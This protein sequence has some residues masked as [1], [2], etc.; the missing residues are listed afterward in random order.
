MPRER[1]RPGVTR[2][3]LAWGARNGLLLTTLVLVPGGLAAAH[4]G[5]AAF[6]DFVAIAVGYLLF[7]GLSGLVVGACRNRLSRKWTAVA[8]GAL[9]GAFGFSILMLFADP[10]GGSRFHLIALAAPLGIVVGAGWGGWFWKRAG[11]WRLR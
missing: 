8:L 7:G 3:D 5:V 11:V 2:G 10:R 1:T 4:E 9:L 6:R